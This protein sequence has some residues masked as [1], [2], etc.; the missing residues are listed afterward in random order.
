MQTRIEIM[1]EIITI[2]KNVLK[3]EQLNITETTIA[4]DVLGWD[5]LSHIVI[6]TTVEK[7]F[8]IKFKA[9]EIARMKNLGEMISAVETRMPEKSVC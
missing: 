6:M 5:S 1:N 9:A 4:Q 3:I 7:K 8:G 2:I